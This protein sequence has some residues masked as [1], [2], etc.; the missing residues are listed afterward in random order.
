M[1]DTQVIKKDG[2][3]DEELLQIRAMYNG[4][5]MVSDRKHIEMLPAAE[6]GPVSHVE[7]FSERNR[8]MTLFL[9]LP[10]EELAVLV[11]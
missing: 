11:N 8:A 9:M 1:T 6:R 4:T 2:I 10:S 7:S 3:S 5:S